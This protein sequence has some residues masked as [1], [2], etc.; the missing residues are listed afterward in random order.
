[1]PLGNGVA[2]AW[3]KVDGN[4]NG[5]LVAVGIDL[6]EKALENL[7]EES[8][9][10][11]LDFPKKK[12]GNFYNN[13]L[14]DWNPHGYLP[15]YGTPHFDFYFYWIPVEEGLAIGLENLSLLNM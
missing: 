6:S 1:M 8:I 10:F 13:M 5:D 2:R 14:V 12:G 3:I 7:P 4:G 15:F 11:V 9:S